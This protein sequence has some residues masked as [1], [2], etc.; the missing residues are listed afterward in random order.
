MDLAQQSVF[1]LSALGAFNG[2]LLSG[3][4]LLIK[5]E[6]RL[7]D[8]FLGGLL[9]MLSIRIFKSVFLYFN[10]ELFQLFV[11]IGLSACS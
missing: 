10:P 2:F 11:Q 4:F 8:Y 3:Y 9:L 7:S 6:K 1:L 5:Q